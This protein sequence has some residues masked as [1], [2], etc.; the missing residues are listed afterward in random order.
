M[1]R[2][3]II[4]TLND[5]NLDKKEYWV[6]AGSAMVLYGLRNETNDIDL[7]CSTNLANTLENDYSTLFFEDGSRR[8]VINDKIEVFEN[9]L[10]DKVEYVEGIP[11]I[12]LKGLL[13][14]K[15]SLG[16]EKDKKD[17]ELI[18]RYLEMQ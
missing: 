6:V 15:E 18:H 11:V 1:N 4:K 14:L 3:E 9:W 16:R 2:Q 8:I 12:S 13:V 10:F 7:G 5:L 17:I